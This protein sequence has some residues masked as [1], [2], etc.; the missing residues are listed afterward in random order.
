MKQRLTR[1][2]ALGMLGVT[3]AAL[4]LARCGES[5]YRRSRRRND[6]DGHKCS[7]CGIA[8]RDRRALS[9]ADRSV[10]KRHPGR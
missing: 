4:S 10:Q 2:E 8:I 5:E 9:F 7:L 1:R 3:G 6:H